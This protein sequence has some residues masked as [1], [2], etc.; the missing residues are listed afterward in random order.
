MDQDRF[1]LIVQLCRYDQ[2]KLT[3]RKTA[4][5]EHAVNSHE[6]CDQREKGRCDSNCSGKDREKQHVSMHF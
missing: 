4:I 6:T 5:G 3:D 2:L 1:T